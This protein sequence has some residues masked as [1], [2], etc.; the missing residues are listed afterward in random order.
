MKPCGPTLLIL[1][2]LSSCSGAPRMPEGSGEG[3]LSWD[4][5]A[6]TGAR[7]FD[8]PIWTRGDRFRYLRGGQEHLDYRVTRAAPGQG[9]ELEEHRT[10]LLLRL[11]ADFA[12]VE[13]SART[14]EGLRR[15]YA[16]LNPELHFPLWVGKKWSADYV[17]KTSEGTAR[18]IRAE[19]RCDALETIQTSV[20]PLECL[21]IWEERR[22]L[23]PERT[24]LA[25]SALHWYAPEVGWIARSLEGG[26][27][28]ELEEYERQRR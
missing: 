26:T 22:L 1:V 21:R 8:K 28:L 16:P 7:T 2:A 15:I 9:Y 27:L 18:H 12:E 20:G 23:V 25:R 11:D 4:R 17:D 24:F 10:G 6:P 13:R 19:F 14:E 5:E 3:M